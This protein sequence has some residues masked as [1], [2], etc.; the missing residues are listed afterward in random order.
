MRAVD[1]VDVVVIGAGIVGLATAHAVLDR[2]PAARVL[3][4]DKEPRV[5][6]HQSGHNSGVIHAGVYYAPGSAKA[7]LCRAGRELMLEFCHRHGIPHRVSGKVV[8]ATT[9]PELG[10]LDALLD[11]S[12]ANGLDVELIGRGR[13]AELEPHVEGLAALHVRDTAVTDFGAVT[14]AL[15]ARLTERGGEVRLGAA[16]SAIVAGPSSSTVRTGQG[17]VRTQ[18]LV[19]CAGLHS[20]RVARLAGIDPGVRILP[21]RGEYHE[22]V[23]A[24]RDLVRTLVYPV[25]DPDLPFLGVHFTRGI[26]GSVH[27]GPNAVPALAREGYRWGAVSVRDVAESL[28]FPGTRRV[29]QRW[30]RTEVG[31]VTRSLVPTAFVAAARQLVPEVRA[32]DLVRAPSGVRAQAVAPDGRLLDDF[33]FVDG[34][35]SVH[36]LNAPSPAATASLAIGT[37]IASRLLG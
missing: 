33:V 1:D 19:N 28:R 16:V 37:H 15:A 34:P 36:V 24:R 14:R 18:L 13:L 11:R 29:A 21:F 5:G 32:H 30:W 35:R 23:P 12:R 25:P 9:V 17:E 26:D 4:L 10:R 6:G 20:D 8:V 2:R 27:V 31:E 7:A 22:L 3:V